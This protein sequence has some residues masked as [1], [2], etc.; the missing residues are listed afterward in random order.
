MGK[1]GQLL[2][3]AGGDIRREFR[4]VKISVHRMRESCNSKAEVDN[5]GKK[6]DDM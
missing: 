2:K 6:W 1:C 5:L 3:K 4:M